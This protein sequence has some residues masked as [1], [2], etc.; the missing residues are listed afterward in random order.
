M[1]GASKPVGPRKPYNVFKSIDNI[2]IYVGRSA[3]ENDDLS[4]NPEHRH[5]DE[6]WLHVADVPGSPVVIK[7][8]DDDLE[9]KYRETL[10]DA[11]TLAAHFS[12]CKNSDVA[13]VHY[14]RCRAVKKVLPKPG[15]VLLLSYNG[16]MNIVFAEETDRLARL[17]ESKTTNS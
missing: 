7:C 12:K 17:L 9:T 14:T 6:W 16:I 4:T 1:N 10:I 13:P 8:T 3:E 11:A 15:L 2:T 5:D